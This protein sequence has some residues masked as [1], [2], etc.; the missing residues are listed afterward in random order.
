MNIKALI[1]SLVL[2]SS[3]AAM[4]A[5][6]GTVTVNASAAY[7]TTGTT[8]VRDHRAPDA[9]L[10]PVYSQRAAAPVYQSPPIWRRPAPR[11]VTL[12]T[13]LHFTGGRT[14]IAVA[15]QGRA[16]GSLQI[17]AAGGRTFIQQVA[18]EF[19][20]G[21]TQVVRKLNA[22]LTGDQSITVDV[23]GDRRN[24]KRVTVYGKDINSG[25]RR[26]AGAFTVTA[27]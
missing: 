26:S 6:A 19:A 14:T 15:S 24:I 11:P 18:I 7:G 23:A 20:N 17:S 4:A 3:S 10:P 27:V 22:T 5:P 1:A 8:V 12:A 13:G 25:W 2:G 21:Q 9:P 16:F